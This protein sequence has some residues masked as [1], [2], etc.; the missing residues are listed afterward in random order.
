MRASSREGRKIVSHYTK[1]SKR[2][3]SCLGMALSTDDAILVRELATYAAES[4]Q[5][6]INWE[7]DSGRGERPIV[8]AM[9]AYVRDARSLVER[10]SDD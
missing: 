9:R 6:V 7:V 8:D 2:N 3:H 1:V 10:L 4:M 5:E